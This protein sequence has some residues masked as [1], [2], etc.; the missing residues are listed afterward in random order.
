MYE[1]YKLNFGLLIGLQS[2]HRYGPSYG[3]RNVWKIGY[4]IMSSVIDI[5]DIDEDMNCVNSCRI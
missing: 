2:I 1:N 5:D 3:Q 4:N